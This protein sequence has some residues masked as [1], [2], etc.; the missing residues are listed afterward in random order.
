MPLPTDREALAAQ[1]SMVSGLKADLDGTGNYFETDQA[2][3][4]TP[5][6]YIAL[7]T[8][9]GLPVYGL[10]ITH[11][12]YQMTPTAAET[13]TIYLFEAANADNLRNLSD[14]VFQSAA[15]QASATQYIYHDSGSGSWPGLTTVDF[16]LPQTCNL[17]DEGKLYYLLD[18]TGAPGNTPGFIKVRGRLML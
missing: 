7:T 11:L 17:A 5:T 2:L 8:N 4:D 3:G 13:Y 10:E 14:I 16:T 9:T 12:S 18:W 15:A 1:V 6:L